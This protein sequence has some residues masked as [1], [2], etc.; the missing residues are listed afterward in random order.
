[1]PEPEDIEL[2]LYP[3]DNSAV[4]VEQNPITSTTLTETEWK[5][6]R[7]LAG[8]PGGMATATDFKDRL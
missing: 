7:T 3:I 4:L 2:T 6:L 1:V 8:F 5:M